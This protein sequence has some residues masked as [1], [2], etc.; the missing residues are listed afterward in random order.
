[1]HWIDYL[2]C[3]PFLGIA[4]L[5]LYSR[6]YIRGVAD[7]LAAGRVAGRY[8]ICVGDMTANLSVIMLIAL[9]EERYNTGFA[10]AFWSGIAAPVGMAIALSGYCVYRFRETRALSFGQFIEM[11]YN[12][13]LRIFASSLRT[14]T[15]ML[16]NAIGPA[17]T[18]NFF[19]YFLDM[20]HAVNI[21]GWLLPVYPLIAALILA[22]ALL[23]VLPGGRVSLLITD[24]IQGL[25]SYPIFLII[26]GYVLIH[27]SWDNEI[28]PTLV[29][30]VPGE[31]FINPLDMERLR[32]FNIFATITVIFSQ[33]L[34]CG[35]WIGNDTTSAGRNA[36]EQKMAGI[37][38]AWRNGFSFVMCTMLAIAVLAVMNHASYQKEGAEVRGGISEMIAGEIASSPEEAQKIVSA[39]KNAPVRLIGGAEAVPLYSSTD[40]ADTPMLNAVHDVL[41]HDAEGNGKFQNFRSIYSQMLSPVVFRT[42]FPTGLTGLV[43]LL[44][45][46]LMVSTDASRVF[47]AA[48][49]MTQ[50][51]ILPWLKRSPTP[52]EHIRLIRCNAVGVAVFF[53]VFSLLFVQLDYINM[54]LSI[55][56]SLWMG[57]AG[58]VVVFGLYSQ[59]G[60]TAGAFASIFAG[61]GV[62]LAG[63]LTQRNWAETVY[64]FLTEFGWVEPVGNFLQTVSSPFNPLIVWTMN[65]VKFPINSYEISFIAMIAGIIAYVL[66]SLITCRKPYNLERMLHRGIY[67]LPGETEL[68]REKWTVSTFFR[69]VI[70][71]TSDYT[72]GD[73]IIA[74]AVFGYS[75]VYSMVIAF[76]LVLVWNIISPWN[77]KYWSWYFFIH[78]VVVL[79][80]V[81]IISTIWFSIGGVIDIRRLFRD[82]AD[83]TAN[84]LDNGVVCGNVS[85]EDQANVNAVESKGKSDE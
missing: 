64:P 24:C 80:I 81:G 57:G 36:H 15:E 75:F 26:T 21:C 12:R 25:M 42:I 14:I 39:A 62:A 63:L 51:M 28:M 13:A 56:N 27:F 18:A 69:K 82:L 11:R 23:L 55:I 48:S 35:S 2:V 71:I 37:L 22:L 77:I 19:I 1:M 45:I 72:T 61:S 31:S 67:R 83:R 17:V 65:P 46:L 47:N 5:A 49:T 44:M 68:V 60:T 16:S 7:Y 52:E 78:N 40:N 30:R 33:I 53:F 34:N 41:G 79:G 76:L 10:R 6:H 3:L 58:P 74:Y 20:P 4:Y 50:D 85:L 8:V 43:I 73:K 29:N 32:D 66:V 70:G 84:P 9:I 54:F 59:F 38:G